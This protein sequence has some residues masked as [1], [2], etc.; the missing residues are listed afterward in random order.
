VAEAA[1]ACLS[2]WVEPL[3]CAVEEPFRV[4]LVL[5]DRTDWAFAAGRKEP[6]EDVESEGGVERAV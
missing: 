6:T 5:G 3:E 4:P 1:V 2:E